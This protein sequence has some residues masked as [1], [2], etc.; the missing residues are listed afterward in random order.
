MNI[1]KMWIRNEM[2]IV[3][4]VLKILELRKR[5]KRKVLVKQ[6]KESWKKVEIVRL[7]D[8]WKKRRKKLR[9]K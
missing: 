9:E 3:W 1:L 5:K 8:L 4:E 6:K 2:M 7:R